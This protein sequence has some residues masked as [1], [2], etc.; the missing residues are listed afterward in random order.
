MCHPETPNASGKPLTTLP[1]ILVPEVA[2]SFKEK[3]GDVSGSGST[4]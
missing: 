4:G 2:S 3:K 1:K